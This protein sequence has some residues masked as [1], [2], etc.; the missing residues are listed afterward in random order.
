MTP[1]LSAKDFFYPLATVWNTQRLRITKSSIFPS[2]R[3][4]D[5]QLPLLGNR[6]KGGNQGGHTG[7]YIETWSRNHR[8]A[9]KLSVCQLSSS[10]RELYF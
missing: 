8:S 1:C 9:S 4:A 3:M 2:P 5:E 7:S 6:G 10:G